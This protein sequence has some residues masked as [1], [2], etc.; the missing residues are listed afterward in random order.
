MANT[1]IICP[2]M[3]TECVE[4]GAIR[5]NELVACRYWICVQGKHPQTGEVVNNHDCAIAWLPVLLIE[6][7]KV[8]RETGAAVESLRNEEVKMGGSVIGALLAVAQAQPQ[9]GRH[10]A[11]LPAIDI[12]KED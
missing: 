5:N 6:N 12:T 4:G 9:L 7:S 10:G 1:K 2:M 8:N 3:G 11:A